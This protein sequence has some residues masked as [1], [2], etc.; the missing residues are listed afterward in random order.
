MPEFVQGGSL[1]GIIENTD[2]PGRSALGYKKG[3]KTLRT[4]T[5]R[6]IIHDDGFAEL[7]DHTSSEG[8]TRNIADEQ[9]Q[10]VEELK[11]ELMGKLQ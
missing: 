6:L 9:P 1:K 7:Y 8:E 2:S 4:K 5:H 11:R 3:A 10:K